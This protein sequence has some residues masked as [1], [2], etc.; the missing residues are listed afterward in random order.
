MEDESEVNEVAEEE[1]PGNDSDDDGDTSEGASMPTGSAGSGPMKAVVAVV[2]TAFK[3]VEVT[4][5]AGGTVTWR[6][7]GSQPHSVSANNGSFESS[8]NCSPI[9]ADQCLGEGDAFSEGF[10]QPGTYN[11]YCRVHGLPDGT[12]MV[13]TVTVE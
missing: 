1:S 12:G 7:S 3:A 6:Q 9:K 10:D 5:S 11:Y 2:D 4:I 8:P 13:G